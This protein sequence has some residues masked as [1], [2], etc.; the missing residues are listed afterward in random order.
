MSAFVA[1][2]RKKENDVP[3]DAENEEVGSHAGGRL[4]VRE[5]LCKHR[6]MRQ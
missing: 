5:A 2:G 6:A 4:S 1:R 3:D